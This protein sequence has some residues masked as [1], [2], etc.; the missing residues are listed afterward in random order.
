MRPYYQDESVTLYCGDC[1]D[2][3]EWLAAD[4][5]VTDPPYG[6][7]YVSNRA[8]DGPSDPIAADETTALRDAALSAW[9]QRPA[10]VFGTWKVERPAGTKHLLVWDKGADPGTGDL[11]MPWGSSCEEIYVFGD[12][13]SGKRRSN[14]LRVQ[15]LASQSADRPDHP[16][17]KPIGLME[18]LI[19]YAPPGVIADPF[20]GSGSTLLAARVFGRKSI[21]VE[22]REDYCE[23]I[24]TRLAQGS[25]FAN[26]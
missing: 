2:V 7:S 13:W 24:A 10:L 1:R 9:G 12:G 19:A 8:Q 3:T 26:V 20:A 21:G 4:V 6:M 15:R 16:T 14:V 23:M 25:L 18:Q 22:C 17:P 5:L 11:S